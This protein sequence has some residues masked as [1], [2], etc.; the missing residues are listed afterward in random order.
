MTYTGSVSQTVE[1][2]DLIGR[3]MVV[4]TK[5]RQERVAMNHLGNRGVESY[6]P[7]YLE[8][9]WNRRAV[10]RP[11]PMFTAVSNSSSATAWSGS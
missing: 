2:A 7:M 8:P 11:T 9:S 5:P 6:C 1:M 3:W 4:R 10:N